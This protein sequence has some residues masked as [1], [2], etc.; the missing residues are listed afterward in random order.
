VIPWLLN[1]ATQLLARALNMQEPLVHHTGVFVF[2]QVV[3]VENSVGRTMPDPP[4]ASIPELAAA[5]GTIMPT[6]TSPGARP[7]FARP[8]R[9][10][11]NPTA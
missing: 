8:T 1:L 11:A 3:A 9:Q 10:R 2:A 6:M 5:M 7:P 4:V